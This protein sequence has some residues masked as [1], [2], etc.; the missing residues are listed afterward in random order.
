MNRAIATHQ[1]LE[2]YFR[3]LLED[4][5]AAEKLSL[6]DGS[7]AY[8]LRVVAEF[9][10]SDALHAG[11]RDEPG[12]PA[13]VWLYERAQRS[14]PGQR[15]DALRH[16]GDVS[17]VVSGFFTPHIERERSLVGLDYYVD[18]GT[19]AYRSAA[20]LARRTGF[21]ELLDELARNF[22]RLVEV[23]SYVA[24]RTT[25]PVARDLGAIY[26]RF[27]LTPESHVATSRMFDTGCMP[28]F[29]KAVA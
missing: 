14:D 19:A 9:G 12:T 17:L 2:S 28:I 15:F 3:E 25:L 20:S 4:A 8:L 29:K 16:L 5:L 27:M 18:M 21:S 23:L 11:G 1:T 7:V 26:E 22:A 13:L 6:D 24:E 10:A